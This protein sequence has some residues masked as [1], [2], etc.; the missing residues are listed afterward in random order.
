M[1][2]VLRSEISCESPELPLQHCSKFENLE[3]SNDPISVV[4]HHF[5]RVINPIEHSLHFIPFHHSLRWG[6]MEI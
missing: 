3:P 5:A 2:H 4:A 6:E 1:N